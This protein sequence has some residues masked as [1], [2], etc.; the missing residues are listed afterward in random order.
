MQEAQGKEKA[1]ENHSPGPD[2][3]NEPRKIPGRNTPRSRGFQVVSKLVAR[4]DPESPQIQDSFLEDG[5]SL[6]V[7]A[8]IFHEKRVYINELVHPDCHFINS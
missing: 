3:E 1:E 4:L 2:G 6:G 7:G 8:I 5:C